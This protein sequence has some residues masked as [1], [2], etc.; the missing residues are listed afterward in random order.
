MVGLGYEGVARAWGNFLKYLKRGWNRKEGRG[1]KDFKKG[2]GQ[3]G[4]R[5]GCVKKE[6]ERGGW[7][8]LTNYELV[9]TFKQKIGAS[10]KVSARK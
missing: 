7:N 2:G 10:F 5:S 8:P 1:N 4:S 3:A 6:R 9:R